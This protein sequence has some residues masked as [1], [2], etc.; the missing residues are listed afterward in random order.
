LLYNNLPVWGRDYLVIEVAGGKY[1]VGARSFF[2]NNLAV[3]ELAVATLQSWLA[4]N[5]PEGGLLAALYCGV[6]LFSLALADRFERV[7]AADTDPYAL[8][9]AENNLRRDQ[10][11]TGKA[12][13]IR[14][15]AAD[16]LRGAFTAAGALSGN[17]DDWHTAC[18]LLDPPRAGLGK[19]GA[20]ALLAAAPRD[21]FYLSCHPATLARDAALLAASGYDLVRLAVLDMFPQT[22]H[23]E[24]LLQLARM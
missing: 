24:C 16:A 13:A 15:S 21:V 2:Q 8:R 9:D 11:T 18:V 17:D 7:L 12:T 22:A 20:A 5:R 4:A 10:R 3:T 14:A 6:G 1:R 23:V 19:D